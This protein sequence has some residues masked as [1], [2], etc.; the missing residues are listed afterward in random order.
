[1]VGHWAVTLAVA[2]AGHSASLWAAWKAG[3]SGGSMAGTKAS[4]TVALKDEPWV[5]LSVANL[6]ASSVVRLVVQ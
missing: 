3:L 6:V 4:L 5:W 2:M 1:M